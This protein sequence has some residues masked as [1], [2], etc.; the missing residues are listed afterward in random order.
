MQ[1]TTARPDIVRSVRHS[2]LLS[3]WNRL[4]GPARLPS[5][6]NIA[7]EDLKG[8]VDSL[9]FCD[10]EESAGDGFRLLIRYR[11]ARITEVYGE[12]EYHYLDETLPPLLRSATLETYRHAVENAQPVYTVVATR[13]RTGCPVDFERLLLPFSRDGTTVDRIVSALEWISI[14]NGFERR[15]LLRTQ[16]AA[17]TYSVCA[18]IA[19]A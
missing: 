2:F 7:A 19:H 8:H 18:A 4:R 3:Y 12:C 6:K 11:G 14:E 9:M 17:P 10:V 13:D 16:V 15:E 5:W 1:F